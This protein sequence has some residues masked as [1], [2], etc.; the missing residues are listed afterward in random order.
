MNRGNARIGL[1]AMLVLTLVAGV[2]VMLRA[3]E[4]DRRTTVV[5]YLSLIHI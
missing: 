3:S 4:V 5:A 2:V 1:A